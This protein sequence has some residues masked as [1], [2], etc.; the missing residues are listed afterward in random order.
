MYYAVTNT[1]FSIEVND[2]LSGVKTIEVSIDSA[3]YRPYAGSFK[4]KEGTH[5]IRCRAVDNAGN[6]QETITGEA[7]SVPDRNIVVHVGRR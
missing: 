4:L 3:D 6:Q 5:S 2:D 7:I 1:V